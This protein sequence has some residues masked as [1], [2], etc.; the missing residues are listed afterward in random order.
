MTSGRT[1][2]FEHWKKQARAIPIMDEI[3]RR[4]VKLK[5]EGNEFIG[6][7]PL[8]RGDDRFAVNTKKEVW[9]CRGC[10]VG[11]DV[12]ELVRHLDG[13]DF[14]EACTRL[15]GPPPAINGKDAAAARAILTDKYMYCDESGAVLFAALRISISRRFFRSEKRQAQKDFSRKAAGS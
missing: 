15:A 6:P 9:N 7:C 5:R 14:I 8:C 1:S 12:I 3:A 13:V 4:G 11:G 2:A 10:G